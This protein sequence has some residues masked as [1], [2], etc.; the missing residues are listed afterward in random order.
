MAAS[1]SRRAVLGAGVAA[2]PVLSSGATSPASRPLEAGPYLS[3]SRTTGAFPL[4]GAPVV[5]D[6]D[7][8]PG[9]VRVAADLRADI[10]RVTGVRPGGALA[11]ERDVVLV[12]TI[13]R[14]ALIDGLVATGKLDVS[15]VRG[16]WE[17]S[18]QTV[19]E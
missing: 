11:R 9:V 12:G 17:T 8:H 15:G 1:V 2:V 7:D 19:V 14:S 18:L 10:E 5:V 13:G 6:P 3:F 4:V 16:R